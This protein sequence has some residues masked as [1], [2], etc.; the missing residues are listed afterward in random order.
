M[1]SILSQGAWYGLV[2][3][4]GNTW[5]QY[6]VHVWEPHPTDRDSKLRSIFYETLPFNP[7]ET[8]IKRYTVNKSFSYMTNI[9]LFDSTIEEERQIEE[10]MSY[11]TQNADRALILDNADPRTGIPYISQQR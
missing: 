5:G 9:R 11:F 6:N 7:E 10:L 3:Y 2:F 1:E 8:T 4:V